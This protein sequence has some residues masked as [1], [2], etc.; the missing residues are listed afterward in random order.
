MA[1]SINDIYQDCANVILEPGGF[2]LG[3]VSIADFINFAGEIMTDFLTKTGI[4]K[5]IVNINVQ[6]GIN[7]YDLP[8]QIDTPQAGSYDQQY[9]HHTSTFYL[10]NYDALWLSGTDYSVGD[11]ALWKFD[12]VQSKQMQVSPNPDYSGNQCGTTLGQGFYGVLSAVSNTNDFSIVGPSTGFFGAISSFTGNPYI[13]ALAPAYGTWAAMCASSTNLQIIATGL[14]SSIQVSLN[15]YIQQIPDSF[16]PAIKYGIL[17]RIFA[18][19]GEM[20]DITKANYCQA[21]YSELVSLAA[22]IMSEEFEEQT[23]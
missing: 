15:T 17:S 22:S 18:Q 10:D 21:R 19:D 14:P 9:I 3:L 13:C 2:S 6:A 4:S 5:K 20:K 16:A 23:A 1:V 11:P 8:D 7:I 12:E